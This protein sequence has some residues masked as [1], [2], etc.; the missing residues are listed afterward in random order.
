MV[1]VEPE[2]E[3]RAVALDNVSFLSSAVRKKARK[4]D[5]IQAEKR[6]IGSSNKW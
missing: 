3:V 5:K 1:V 2:V 4:S 6:A